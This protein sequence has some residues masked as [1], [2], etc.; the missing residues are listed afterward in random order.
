MKSLLGDIRIAREYFDAF[1]PEGLKKILNLSHLEHTANS[2]ISE[3]LKETMAD[4]VFICPLK[5]GNGDQL[6]YLSLLFEHKSTPYKFVSIQIGGYLFDAYRD[7][8]KNQEDFM[9]PVIPFL[10]YHGKDEWVPLKMGELFHG[11]ST[12]I[13]EYIPLIMSKFDN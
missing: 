4:I 6:L 2:F 13:T 8:L 7:Q 10:Y 9:I 11:F 5:D 3:H 1:L 12:E